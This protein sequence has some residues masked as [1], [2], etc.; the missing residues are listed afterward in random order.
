MIRIIGE[1]RPTSTVFTV[2]PLTEFDPATAGIPGTVQPTDIENSFK[3]LATTIG[4]T[5][6]VAQ[7]VA[8]LAE[9]LREGPY[10]LNPET[11]GGVQQTLIDGFLRTTQVGNEAQFVTGFVLLARSLGVDA[12]VAT[13]YTI[14]A[15]TTSATIRTDDAGRLGRSTGRRRLGHDRRG[16][17]N[18]A[19]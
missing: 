13:G 5:G 10:T 14:D 9:E 1:E 18:R 4:G 16:S 17:R 15:T 6:T 19:A 12:R 3:S 11:P 8:N 2:E 7:Q